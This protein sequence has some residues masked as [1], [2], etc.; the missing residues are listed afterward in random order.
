MKRIRKQSIF[1]AQMVSSGKTYR[2]RN[3]YEH[4]LA[5]CFQTFDDGDEI[6]IEQ[7]IMMVFRKKYYEIE[8]K[9]KLTDSEKYHLY[10]I[11]SILYK[12]FKLDKQRKRII[13]KR[14]HF[15]SNGISIDDENFNANN[16]T[17]ISD[18]RM[19]EIE[20][21]QVLLAS[22]LDIKAQKELDCKSF[23]DLC[24]LVILVTE[25]SK[26]TSGNQ[27]GDKILL[28]ANKEKKRIICKMKAFEFVLKTNH[29]M[30]CP[31]SHCLM[32]DPVTTINNFN[33]ER[34]R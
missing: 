8:K 10:C 22:I 2:N 11:D 7:K 19:K 5:K 25:E 13:K 30:M 28:F 9:K 4:E 27:R 16:T 17:D 31:I 18:I 14:N 29:D 26:N 1:F 23:D 6:E 24:E 15:R 12:M 33:Y 34:H 32:T 20:S 21:K 3:G